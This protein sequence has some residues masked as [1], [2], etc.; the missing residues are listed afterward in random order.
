MTIPV[1]KEGF[2]RPDIFKLKSAAAS[3]ATTS[4]AE[5]MHLVGL[6]PEAPTLEAALAPDAEREVIAITRH[7]LENS[8]A[9]LSCGERR[10]V[11]Y[12]SVGCPHLAPGQLG[13]MA[14]FL[15]GKK[16]SPNTVL[17]IWTAAPFKEV[18]DR[19]GLTETIIKTGAN[20]LTNTCPL[21]SARL[22]KGAGTVAFDSAKQAHYMTSEVSQKILYGSWQDCLNTAI[23]GV[24]EGAAG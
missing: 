24:W 22:P 13:E 17:H 9:M 19:C 18:A 1:F 15:D 21:V 20:L 10:P 7:D 4:G 8:R 5:M 2:A 12:V 6:T 3:M 23:S 16:I 14:A 11:D